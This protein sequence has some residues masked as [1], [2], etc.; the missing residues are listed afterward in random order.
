MLVLN[1]RINGQLDM[2]KLLNLQLMQ[3]FSVD[4]GVV[5]LL[6]FEFCYFFK[7]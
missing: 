7:I 1:S 4:S 3:I 6:F 5:N 2:G